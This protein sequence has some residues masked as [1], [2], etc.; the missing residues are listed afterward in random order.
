MEQI[1]NIAGLGL[2]LILSILVWVYR[3][4]L[5]QLRERQN[6]IEKKFADDKKELER[7]I[8]KLDSEVRVIENEKFSKIMEELAK[9]N[10]R[11]AV[12]EEI[13]SKDKK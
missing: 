2:S 5:A 11:I 12:I 13:I 9:I 1:L 8:E 7:K 4:N 6:T 3:D 10:T